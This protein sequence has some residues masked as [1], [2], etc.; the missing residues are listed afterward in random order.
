MHTTFT[1]LEIRVGIPGT[2]GTYV[3]HDKKSPDRS[4]IVFGTIVLCAYPSY[5]L[6]RRT[7]GIYQRYLR[8]LVCE[9]CI[10]TYTKFFGRSPFFRKQTFVCTGR[11]LARYPGTYPGTI[12]TMNT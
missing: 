4:K 5:K 1:K 6:S 10:G 8:N 11:Y 9:I 7:V 3:M 12:V 2:R